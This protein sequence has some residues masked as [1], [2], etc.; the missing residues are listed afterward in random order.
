MQEHVIIWDLETVPD[1]EAF[2]AVADLQGK[3]E[4]EVRDGMGDK[5]P[6]LVFHKI[7][8]IGA[9]IASPSTD[10]VAALELDDE[11]SVSSGA[12]AGKLRCAVY[13]RKSTEEGL[14]MVF[15]SL[16]AQREACEAYIASQKPED[17][18]GA[19]P[20]RRWGLVQ[21]HAGAARVKAAD[22]RHR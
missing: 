18:A 17:R 4:T 13:T 2:A 14:D 21:R 16:D 22:L 3:P 9:L 8:C 19:R 11:K 20:L 12:P 1:L 10:A 6:K 7:V 15:N 5:F